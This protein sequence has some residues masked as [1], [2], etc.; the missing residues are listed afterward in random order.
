MTAKKTFLRQWFAECMHPGLGN[1]EGVRGGDTE[2][3]AGAKTGTP[4]KTRA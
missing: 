2:R 1:L 3:Q 4:R